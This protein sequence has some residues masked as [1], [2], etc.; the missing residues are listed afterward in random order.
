MEDDENCAIRLWNCYMG[1][2]KYFDG[3]KLKIKLNNYHNELQKN[4]VS[5]LTKYLG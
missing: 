2:E 5:G 4:V 3:Q 1:E